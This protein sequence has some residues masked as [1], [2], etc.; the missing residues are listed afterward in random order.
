MASQDDVQTPAETKAQKAPLGV[1][2]F[3]VVVDETSFLGPKKHCAPCR[4]DYYGKKCPK[5]S[6]GQ[7]LG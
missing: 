5:C 2:T 4:V 1:N 6:R 7:L 3:A